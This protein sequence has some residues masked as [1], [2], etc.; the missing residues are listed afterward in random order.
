MWLSFGLLQQRSNRSVFNLCLLMGPTAHTTSNALMTMTV[1]KEGVWKQFHADVRAAPKSIMTV[2]RRFCAMWTVSASLKY[3]VE[4]PVAQLTIPTV[5]RRLCAE[6]CVQGR[7]MLRPAADWCGKLYRR[8]QHVRQWVRIPRHE[9]SWRKVRRVRTRMRCSNP[10]WNVWSLSVHKSRTRVR[11]T[12]CWITWTV[13]VVWDVL[14]PVSVQRYLSSV[15][16]IATNQTQTV[17]TSPSVTMLELACVKSTSENRTAITPTHSAQRVPNVTT[18]PVWSNCNKVTLGVKRTI[19]NVNRK[20][21]P[22]LHMFAPRCYRL[23]LW[24]VTG[25]RHN[26]MMGLNATLSVIRE[27]VLRA[28]LWESPALTRFM[29]SRRVLNYVTIPTCAWK[30]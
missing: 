16:D 6:D 28:L 1:S 26:Y 3:C 14:K 10:I 15:R 7:N 18:G 30:S 4:K 25:P 24:A 21:C 22:V 5:C 27:S 13:R 9:V 8:V 23:A 29:F 20:H 11:A 19:I 2:Q 17:K 12:A